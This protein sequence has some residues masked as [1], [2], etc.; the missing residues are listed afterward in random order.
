MIGALPAAFR[1]LNTDR[2]IRVAQQTARHS[3][4]I[5]HFSSEGRR[6]DESSRSNSAHR[7]SGAVAVP[8]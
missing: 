8:P 3:V 2:H 5:V 4:T 6:G 1:Q 7:L